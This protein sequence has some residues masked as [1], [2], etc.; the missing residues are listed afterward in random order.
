[1]PRCVTQQP[2]VHDHSWTARARLTLTHTHDQHQHL[3]TTPL[4]QECR[5]ALAS[6]R[7]MGHSGR[8][9]SSRRRTLRSV[10]VSHALQ[11]GLLIVFAAGFF[12]TGAAALVQGVRSSEPVLVLIGAGLLGVGAYVT[13]RWVEAV[14]P[15]RRSMSVEAVH[16]QLQRTG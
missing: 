15:R 7:L 5:S 2:N 9:V 16:E 12:G 3:D 10:Y 8:V 1:E 13:A 14:W 4:L 11:L 6:A